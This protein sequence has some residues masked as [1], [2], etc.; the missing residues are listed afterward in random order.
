MSTLPKFS[1][2]EW[3]SVTFSESYMSNN[4][5]K[6]RLAAFKKQSSK[7]Y[8]CGCMMWLKNRKHFALEHGISELEASRFQCTGEHLL[9]KCDG[10]KNSYKNIVAACIFCNKTRHKMKKPPVPTRYKSH[11]QTRLGKGKWHPHRLQHLLSQA[12]V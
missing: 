9:A 7:C 6:Q 12:K 2:V 10:G 1:H 11:I 3:T 5:S 4:I 8:Y